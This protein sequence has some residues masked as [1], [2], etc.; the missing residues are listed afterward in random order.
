MR[1][2]LSS[3]T[4]VALAGSAMVPVAQAASFA[5]QSAVEQ[6]ANGL[7]AIETTQFAWGG[8]NYCCIRAAGRARAGIGAALRG[9]AASVGAVA[10]G[11]HGWRGGGSRFPW[12]RFPWRTRRL[13][14]RTRWLPRR[15]R[16]PR[17]RARRRWR[18]PR[19]RTR[20]WR[21]RTWWW[22]PRRTSLTFTDI[23]KTVIGGVQPP[24]FFSF[25]RR[26]PC[27]LEGQ[28]FVNHLRVQL[29]IAAE[30]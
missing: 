26:P 19:W 2:L 4:A 7:M 25:C 23:S 27:N 12:R 10:P 20:R 17:W 5:D 9:G 11:W 3:F 8:R 1:L 24:D 28:K 18:L 14:R 22:W 30:R 29:T 13:G 21:R 15:W 6:S 16:V